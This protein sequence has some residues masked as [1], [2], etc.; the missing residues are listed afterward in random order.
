MSDQWH[1]IGHRRRRDPG[2]GICYRVS[3]CRHNLRSLATDLVV[4]VEDRKLCREESC[5]FLSFFYPQAGETH[6][7]FDLSVGH[8]RN[9]Q[10][11]L[12][13]IL[14]VR[15]PQRAITED[16]GDDIGID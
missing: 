11:A 8:E 1:F 14:P 7:S 15:N 3:F 6:A 16:E 4:R 10:C 13:Q 2:I 5:H 9:A 12:S